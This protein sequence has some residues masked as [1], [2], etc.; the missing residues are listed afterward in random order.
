MRWLFLDHSD[1]GTWQI[2]CRSLSAMGTVH[3]VDDGSAALIRHFTVTLLLILNVDRSHTA[4]VVQSCWLSRTF[5]LGLGIVET[6]SLILNIGGLVSLL[7]ENLLLLI[8]K[9]LKIMFV[10]HLCLAGFLSL[11]SQIKQQ[12][13]SF[14]L[15]DR[16]RQEIIL[17][18]FPS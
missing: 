4:L 10:L 17:Q 9:L 1:G 18:K 13:L 3:F 6:E 7:P 15:V 12:S 5:D 11:F 2:K 14:G 16:L 8:H